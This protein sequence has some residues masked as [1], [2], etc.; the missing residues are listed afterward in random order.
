M[1]SWVSFCSFQ[2]NCI[3]VQDGPQQESWHWGDGS[4]ADA[5]PNLSCSLQWHPCDM[6]IFIQVRQPEWASGQTPFSKHRLLA[7]KGNSLQTAWMLCPLNL[8]N[9]TNSVN[10]LLRVWQLKWH[11]SDTLEASPTLHVRGVGVAAGGLKSW[12][13]VPQHGWV[14][15]PWYMWSVSWLEQSL[16]VT[17]F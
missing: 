4:L 17:L 11:P 6:E 15:L 13:E 1:P 3:R 9:L 10:Y 5:R 2:G 12:F 14:F 16:L 7:L 8:E